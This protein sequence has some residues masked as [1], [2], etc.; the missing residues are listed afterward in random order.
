MRE[1]EKKTIDH[2]FRGDTLGSVAHAKS[3]DGQGGNGKGI[4]T[5]SHYDDPS[6]YKNNYSIGSFHMATLE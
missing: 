6:R 5:C 2:L 4:R 3:S 1:N